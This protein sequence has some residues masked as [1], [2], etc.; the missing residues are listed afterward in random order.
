MS[1]AQKELRLRIVVDTSTATA[2]ARALGREL[3]SNVGVG[4]NA[5]DKAASQ[6]AK[7][8]N[9]LQQAGKLSG[10][11]SVQS[12]Q[13]AAN[14]KFEAASQSAKDL[15]GSFG[16]AAN[17]ASFLGLSGEKLK[18]LIGKLGQSFPQA[19]AAAH[20]MFSPIGGALT[21]AIAGFSFLKERIDRVSEALEGV[22]LGGWGE[23]IKAKT[24]SLQESAL[25][26]ELFA[27]S[28]SHIGKDEQSAE[29]AS[30]RAIER[31]EAEVEAIR[32]VLQAQK[33]LALARIDASQEPES[34][35][36]AQKFAIESASSKYEHDLDQSQRKQKEVIKA[37][38]Y[39]QTSN[40]EIKA[41]QNLRVAEAKAAKSKASA[42][43]LPE[44]LRYHEDAVAALNKKIGQVEDLKSR[45]GTYFMGQEIDAAF[46]SYTAQRDKEQAA[47]NIFNQKQM[48][49]VR[50]ARI[51][52]QEL[53]SAR[54]EVDAVRN[55]RSTLR[56]QINQ[57]K[58]TGDIAQSGTDRAFNASNQE[59][60]V[61]YSQEHTQAQR[62]E[63]ESLQKYGNQSFN[64]SMESVKV[65]RFL[66]SQQQQ[67]SNEIRSLWF[68]ISRIQSRTAASRMYH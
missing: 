45:G 46:A 13:V 44:Q 2:N 20:L 66:N 58:T 34:V 24:K 43:G 3:S 65:S 33:S 60:Q 37:E 28:L 59:R 27:N 25:D 1:D 17:K 51:D 11:L 19:G 42:A 50:Q 57:E 7:L 18:G 23:A 55:R 26:A 56:G 40:R 61:R 5:A 12:R 15:A 68:E 49:I 64:N 63:W 67:L 47:L 48:P 54:S 52:E 38:E 8:E 53:Q 22:A 41:D 35:K 30:N 39:R 9:P 29:T 4:G 14:A 62:E 16:V 32:K 36:L 6:I 10:D 21:L 31:L